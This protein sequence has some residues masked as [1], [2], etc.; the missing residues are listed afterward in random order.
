MDMERERQL[1]EAAT[2]ERMAAALEDIA[3]TAV[4]ADDGPRVAPAIEK[5][6]LCG[7]ERKGGR[8]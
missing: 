1:L 2:L 3:A 6:P 8:A 7:R 5:C 4:I